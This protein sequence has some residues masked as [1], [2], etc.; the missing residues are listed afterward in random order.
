MKIE[1]E[2]SQSLVNL[3]KRMKDK[4]SILDAVIVMRHVYPTMSLGEA[5]IIVEKL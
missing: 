3:L 4:M 5:K 2:M 1:I